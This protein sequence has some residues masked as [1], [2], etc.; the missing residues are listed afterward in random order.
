LLIVSA[1]NSFSWSLTVA[2]VPN[3]I[4]HLFMHLGNNR[5]AILVATIVVVPIVGSVLEGMPAVLVFGPLLVPIAVAAGINPL[6]YG[7]VFVIALGL[8]TFAPPLGVGLFA[9]CAVCGVE[10]E[11]VARRIWPLW[12]AIAIGLVAIAFVP[13][14]SQWLPSL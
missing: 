11:R 1:A 4:S 9:T 7:I 6:Q 5:A 8:G 14:I 10:V 2:G 13:P 12:G 3:G